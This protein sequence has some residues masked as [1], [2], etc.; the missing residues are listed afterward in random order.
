MTRP[1][2]DATEVTAV[3]ARQVRAARTARNWS[4]RALSAASGVDHSTLSRIE[5]GA[6]IT[7][8]LAARIAGALGMPLPVLLTE[9]ACGHCLDAP[10]RGY[11]CQEC[12]APGP[13]VTRG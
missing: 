2:G 6:G 3:F 5:K 9:A 4:L 1:Q 8:G 10:P 11:T 12:G 13:A 7:L